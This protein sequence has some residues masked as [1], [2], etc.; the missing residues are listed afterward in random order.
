M[1]VSDLPFNPEAFEYLIDAIIIVD[2]K[3]RITYLN[4]V[5]AKLYDL[6]KEK[7]LG[8]KITEIF[9]VEWS[10][11]QDQEIF[12]SSI[13]QKNYWSGQNYHIKSNGHKFAAASSV[14]VF[15]KAGN[16]FSIFTVQE[17]NSTPKSDPQ[18]SDKNPFGQS[19]DSSFSKANLDLT[20]LIDVQ[21]LQS[22]MD[23]LYAVSKIGF[24]LI[25]LR[26][27]VLAAN[28]WQ[29]I[30]AKFHR[31]N[32]QSLWNCLESDLILTQGVSQGE[33]RTYKCKNNLWD[34]VTPI[35]I[36]N[37]HVGNLFSG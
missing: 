35:V 32:P 29:D 8:Q 24:A 1:A 23:D 7:T 31:V 27:N 33:F 11:P 9:T 5:A 22:M 16:K 17:L 6:P 3:Q 19:L 25:D 28:G 18:F 14:R 26:G 34:I 4:G 20:N 13:E 30:C 2:K 21:A 10:A 37:K 12:T 15:E 36:G